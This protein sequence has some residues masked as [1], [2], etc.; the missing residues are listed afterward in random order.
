[1]YLHVFCLGF[2]A[3]IGMYG[4]PVYS[5]LYWKAL[6][7]NDLYVCVGRYCL[8]LSVSVMII[9]MHL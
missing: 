2:L 9:S 3:F 8:N 6:V 5:A 1:M 7:H 4:M